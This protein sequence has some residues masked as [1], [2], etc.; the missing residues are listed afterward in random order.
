MGC[1]NQPLLTVLLAMLQNLMCYFC[2]THSSLFLDL[3]LL[4]VPCNFNTFIDPRRA[5][6]NL[7]HQCANNYDTNVAIVVVCFI[8]AKFL[9]I[10]LVGIEFVT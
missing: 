3:P 8:R 6:F 4:L 9:E 5:N 10:Q 1:D 2:L 7:V